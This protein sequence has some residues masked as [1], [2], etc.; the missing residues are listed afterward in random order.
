MKFNDYNLKVCK[1]FVVF[2]LKNTYFSTIFLKT[3]LFEYLNV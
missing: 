3:Y 1:L 2:N